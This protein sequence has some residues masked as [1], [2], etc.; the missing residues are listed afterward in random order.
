M[1]SNVT[2]MDDSNQSSRPDP[3][4]ALMKILSGEVKDLHIPHKT[5]ISAKKIRNG[6]LRRVAEICEHEKKFE[7]E[8]T[9]SLILALDE[10]AEKEFLTDEVLNF[11]RDNPEKVE[12]HLN[13]KYSE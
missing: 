11:L 12:K 3:T 10:A 7:P 4:Q 9:L 1:D 8:K 6:V 13:N 5:L 2:T